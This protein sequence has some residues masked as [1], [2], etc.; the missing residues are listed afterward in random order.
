MQILKRIMLLAFIVSAFAVAAFAQNVNVTAT[1][2]TTTATY[3]TLT[4]AFNAVN[5]GTHTGAITMSIVASTTEPANTSAVLNSSGAGSASY[6]SVVIRPTVD[7]VTITGTGGASGSCGGKGLIELNGADNVTIDGDNPNSAGTNRNLTLTDTCIGTYASVIRVALALTVVTSADN[8]TFRNLVINGSAPGRNISTAT[9]TTGTENTTYGILAT[10]GA[11]ATSATTAPATITS[12]STLIAAGPTAS[13]LTIDNNSITTAARGIAVQGSGT[14]VFPGLTITGN[15]I[16]NPTAGAVDGIYSFGI[17]A[18]GSTNAVI[19]ANIVNVE[20]FLATSIRG[21][22]TGSISATGSGF[23]FERNQVNRVFNRSTGGQGAYGINI[24][25]GNGHT[26]RNNFVSNVSNVAN[27]TFS[28]TFG[29]HGIRIASGIGHFIYHNSVNMYGDVTGTGAALTSALTFVTTTTTGID[30]RNNALVNTQTESLAATPASSAFVAIYLPTGGTSGYAL[31]LNN[32]DYYTGATPAVNNGYGQSGTTAG[33][34]FFTTFDATQTTPATNLRSY[35]ST[36]S[37]AGTNDNASKAV[38]PQFVSATDLHIAAGSPLVDMGV[39]V[40]VG[41]DI[42]AQNR[43]PP[44]DIGADEPGGITPPSNDIAATA[45]IAPANGGTF[46]FGAAPSPQATFTNVGTAAQANVMVQFTITGPGGYSYSNTQTIAAI[47]PSQTVTVTFAA[48]PAFTTAGSYT[49]TATVLTAD[50]N[51]ANNTVSGSFTVVAPV[52]GGNVNVGTGQTYTSL[53]NAGGLFAALNAGGATGNIVINITSDLTGETGAVAL[54]ELAGGLT[55]TI[56][57]SGAA[58]NISGAPSAALIALNGADN[59]TID[60]SLSGGTDRSLTITFTTGTAG[61]NIGSGTN[62]AQNNTVK[63]VNVVGYSPTAA[64]TGI[65]TGGN[66]VGSTAAAFNNNN[67]IQNNDV[68]GTTYGIF[69]LGQSA[70]A[71]NTGTVITQNTMIGT[72]ANGFGKAGIY[73]IYDDGGQFTKNVIDGVSS[74][75]SGVDTVGMAIGQQSV[76]TTT[77][78]GFEVSNATI[79]QNRIGAVVQTATYSAVGIL[80]GPSA[81]GTNTVSNNFVSGVNSNGTSGDF[82][83]GIFIINGAGGTQNVYFNSVSMTGDRG[84]DASMYG[85]YALAIGGGDN[86]TNVVDNILYNTQTNTSTATTAK[87]Y[88]YGISYAAFT[89]LTSNYN[90]LFVG[91]TLGTVGITGGLVN[92]TGTDRVAFTDFTTATGKDANSK[93]V[94]PLFVSATDLHIQATSPVINMGIAAGGITTDFD[95]QTRDAMP[96]IGADEILPAVPGTLALS[97]ATYTVAENAAGGTVT[98]TVNRTGGTDGAVG[99]TYALTNGTATGGATC[100]AGVDF[101]NTGGTVSFA[102]GVMSQ[103]FTVAICNDTIFEGNETF[104]VTLSAPTG[105][106][107]IGTPS[108]AVVTIMDDEMAQPGMLQLSAATY[109]VG[110]AGPTVTITATRTGGTDGAVGATYAL[111]NGTATGGA[112]CAAGIDYINTGGTVSFATGQASQ[113]F[114]VAIC[115]D[116]ILEGNETFN[117]TLSAPTGGATIGTPATAVVTIL[118]DEVAQPGVLQFSAATYSVGEAGGTATVTVTRTGG[119][120]GAVSANYTLANGTATGGASC[121]AGIDFVN[122]GGTVSFAN[123]QASQTFTVAICNDTVFEGNETFNVTLA[124]ATGGATI[125][126]PAT[127]T[128]T[129]ID[130]EVAQPG[131]LQFGSSTYSVGEAT[132]TVTLTVTRTGGTDGAVGATYALAN[133][134]ATGGA[135]CAPGIDFVNTGGTVSFTNGQASQTIAVTICNDTVFEGNETFTATLSAATGGATIGTPAT[136]TVTIIDDETAQPGTLQLSAATYTVAENVAGGT[137]TVTVTRTGGTDGAVTVNYALTDGTATGGATCAAGV[138]FVNTGGT[139]SFANGEAS[140]TFTVAICNDTLVESSE[141]FNVTLS[142]PTGG[143]TVGTPATATVTITDDDLLPGLSGNVNVGAGQTYTSLTNAGGAFEALNT[144]GATGNVTFSITSDLT[145]ETGAVALNE[146]VGGFTVTIK[147]SGAARTISGTS[148]ASSGVIILNGTDNVTIDG[149]L[150]GGTD[151]SLTITNATT[152]SVVIWIRSASATNGATNDTVKNTNLAG[153]AATN[154]IAGI[155]TGS[156]TFGSAAAAANSNNTIQNNNI[157]R[158][159]NAVFISGVATTFDQNWMITGNT[160]GSTVAAEKL[161][162]R[163]MLIGNAQ[164]FVISQNTI[165][166]VNSTATSTSIMNG[167]QVATAANGGLITRNNI[168][169][170]KQTNPGGFGAAGITLGQAGT[171]A[172]VTVANNFIRDVTGAGFAGVGANDN[173]YGITVSAGGGYKI[174]FNSINLATSQTAAGSITGALNITAA[175][176]ATNAIDL[177]DNILVNTETVGTGYAVIN[178]STAAAAVFTDINYNDYFAQNVGRQGTTDFPTL[179]DWRG[180]TG[181]DVNSQAVDPL[182]VSATDLHLQPTS[183]VLD[184]GT[185]IA[186]I[187]NDF[188]GDL[189]SATTP[190]IG[191]DEIVGTAPQ[192]GTLAL[193]A[194]TYSVGEAAGTVTVTVNRTNGT[195]GAVSAN[196]TLANGTATGGATCAAGIDFVNTGGTVSFA[197]GQASQTFTVAICNDTVFEGNETFNVT[198]SG[199]TGGATIGTPATATVTIVDDE[200]AQP[201]VLQ[202]NATT[203]SVGEAAG[204]ATVTVTRTGGTDGAVTVNYALANGT[205]TGGATCAAGVDYINTGGTVSFANG[206]TSKTFTVMIC[207]DTVV[208]SNETFTATL[209]AATGGA[210]IGTPATATITII[211]DD[212]VVPSLTINDVRVFEGDTGTVNAVFTVTASTTSTTAFSVTYSTADNTAT[213]GVDYT[214]V[215][216][217]LTFAPGQ[218]TR[219]ITV[220]IIGDLLM[221]ANETFFVNLNVP[222]GATIADPQGI[223]II[224]D[225]DRAIVADFD[226]DGRTDFS[227]FRP[228]NGYWYVLPSGGGSY[229]FTLNG[230][231]GDLPVPGDYDGD[232]KT[233]YAVFRPSNGTWYIRRSSDNVLVQQQWGFG[234]DKPVQGDFDGDGKTDIAVFR[235]SNGVWYVLRSS[236]GTLIVPFGTNG[237]VPVQGDY[238]GDAKTDYAVYRN[239]VWYVMNSSNGAVSGINFGAATDKPLVGDFDGDGKSDFTVYRSG[240]WYIFQTL[241][242]TSRGVAFGAANDIPVVGDYDGDG[243]SDIA[244]FRPSTGIWYYLRSSDN[245]FAGTAFG[246][247]GDIP[248]PSGYQSLQ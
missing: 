148:A 162:F 98:I 242:G 196:Y 130:D 215:S 192:N 237:D 2:G 96:D 202:F 21:I 195:D 230:V 165:M 62:G 66:S 188:D 26:I 113:T 235:P 32:N 147:P 43:V 226:N 49:M 200:V 29:A 116:T 125:G 239:G 103:T 68:K 189:R 122:T 9:S 53:T 126:T 186:G 183:P 168:S 69:S 142:A 120:D 118:D 61:I 240:V 33:T 150:S 100:A 12:T 40:G 36:L 45:I 175:V 233:D 20:S 207:N 23:T 28:T 154:I 174:Y 201:G 184:D 137:V 160:F 166:G 220:P 164:N 25:S 93:N 227:V 136:A 246:Q 156:S 52:A 17:T 56:K 211:D 114:T 204:T 198:L 60:G 91:G 79:S 58:R 241:T 24:S 167:I 13:N 225:D 212:V 223:G 203:Y 46:G 112:T 115:N 41:Q 182:F 176:T 102:N 101:I 1:G 15:N 94:D 229:T 35:T 105:G 128:V 146:V 191:A 180:A 75:A 34:G 177:R 171:T 244:V 157:I 138:D 187:T 123:G 243:T 161:S 193:S 248:I 152:T 54:N 78:T 51:S 213:A 11:S 194:A 206:E 59:V 143:A 22:D 135:S 70:T 89:N 80:L 14:A 209:S 44:P 134:T 111:T 37:A 144:L 159:Q 140:K 81:T 119:T 39:D 86:A 199:A 82:A 109:S 132:S 106:A 74:A 178:S 169:D 3:A 205:A 6:T 163:G 76:T 57:P 222:T 38:N 210:T 231:N 181:K 4:D 88:A 65:G 145:G 217:T 7:G 104:S 173:G 90:D 30:A 139:V 108:T 133:G 190:D 124:G 87:S 8:N 10:G 110:E 216:G 155:L 172:N 64:L 208:E 77:T 224:V 83:V 27:A 127:A 18:Q 16:G 232:A 92:T 84:A 238:D 234:T 121:A 67:R 50:Q 151:R 218:T 47:T 117:V 5:A 99:A 107:T 72:G 219:T 95:G 71:K 153:S 149:S 131:T 221:E 19:R 247:N 170:I 73:V 42:D 185:P 245:G 97:S 85:S 228:S 55:V 31:N 158:A 63:N 129:I 179:T 214:A 141:T 197:N 236:G 48:V